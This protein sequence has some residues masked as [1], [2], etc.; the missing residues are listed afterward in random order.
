MKLLQSQNINEVYGLNIYVLEKDG[1]KIYSFRT[2]RLDTTYPQIEII[3]D[4]FTKEVQVRVQA[5]ALGAL[6]VEEMTA[7]IEKLQVATE[8]AEIIQVTIDKKEFAN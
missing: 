1:N 8:V 5:T 6:S 3:T 7:H 2:D 4:Y